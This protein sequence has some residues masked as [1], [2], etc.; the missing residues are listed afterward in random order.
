MFSSHQSRHLLL[1]SLQSL[2][3]VALLALLL[4][5]VGNLANRPAA[6]VYSKYY[7]AAHQ[8]LAHKPLYQP[9]EPGFFGVS[10]TAFYQTPAIAE[11][12]MHMPQVTLLLTP[13]VF[14]AYPTS[15]WVW[16]ILSLA[17]GLFACAISWRTL[18][19]P[20]AQFSD[21][22]WMWIALLGF[23]PTFFAL[24][25]GQAVFLLFLLLMLGWRAARNNHDRMAGIVIG[26]AMSLRIFAGLLFFYFLVKRRWQLALWCAAT[27]VVTI[28]LGLMFAGVNAYQDWWNATRS[29]TWYGRNWNASFAS[30]FTRIF[31]GTNNT[32]W[33]DRPDVAWLLTLLCSLACIALLAWLS[34]PRHNLP[35]QT[36]LDDLTFSLTSAFMLLISPLGWMYYFPILFVGVFVAWWQTGHLLPRAFRWGIA[37]AWLLSMTPSLPVMAEDLNNPIGWF[38]VDSVYFYSLLVFTTTLTLM[39]RRLLSMSRQK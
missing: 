4:S 1:I 2:L 18:Y 35:H 30:F 27:Y 23:V 7:F 26:L 5:A 3:L 16:S 6:S 24:V 32:A 31:G 19:A 15:Y 38:T 13:M 25:G 8:A 11:P 29:V 39:G 12:P 28:L 34:W 21:L 20:P 9:V 10:P 33:V 37:L 22:V 14:L 17:A 36:E